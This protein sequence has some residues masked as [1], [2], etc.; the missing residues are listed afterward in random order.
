M[1]TEKMQKQLELLQREN[2][3]FK[4]RDRH[5][6]ATGGGRTG[7]GAT[8][9]VDTKRIHELEGSVEELQVTNAVSHRS[10]E[11]GQRL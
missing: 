9:E 6:A 11:K 8:L 5:I 10:Q 2:T 4:A 3:N 1:D 7:G